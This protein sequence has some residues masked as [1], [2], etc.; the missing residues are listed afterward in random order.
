MAG[1]LL[2]AAALALV[3]GWGAAV[4]SLRA[5]PADDQFAVAANHFR[6]ANWKLA[7][8]EFRALVERFPDDARAPVA[9][10]YLGEAQ[11]QLGDLAGAQK[12]FDGY[13]RK[14]PDGEHARTALFRSGESAHVAGQAAEADRLLRAFLQKNPKDPL[15][16]YV[17][18]YLGEIASGKGDFE[19][20]AAWFGQ[21]LKD[22]PNGPLQDDCRYGLGRAFRELGRTEEA[23]RLF[24]A[25]SAKTGSPRADEALFYLGVMQ[26]DATRPEE[27]VKSFRELESKFS[28]SPQLPA[29]RLLLG[30]ALFQLQRWDEARTALEGLK[31]DARLGVRARYW[32]GRVQQEQGQWAAAAS[33]LIAAAEAAP[34]H[35]LE[36]EIRFEAGRSLAKAG[37]GP[38]AQ[39]QFD[40]AIAAS[41]ENGPWLDEALS[42]KAQAALALKDHELVDRTAGQFAER[43]PRS[44]LAAGVART[45]AQSLIERGRYPEALEK[46]EPWLANAGKD[47]EGLAARY[48]A[49]LAYDGVGRPKDALDQL[50]RAGASDDPAVR[51]GALLAKAGIRM[52]AEQFSEAAA[53]LQALL[54]AA[55]DEQEALAARMRLAV[56]LARTRQLDEAR[57]MYA[58]VVEQ[59]AASEAFPAFEE[60]LA[61]AALDAGDT[62]WSSAL[63]ERLAAGGGQS[64]AEK[65]GLA[66]LGWSQL[67]AGRLSDAAAT[68]GRL[69]QSDPPAALAAEAAHVR[70]TILEKL[71]QPDAALAMY[72]RVIDKHPESQQRADALLAAAR[73]RDRLDQD[74][75]AVALF[76]RFVRD[77]PEHAE[78]DRALY[79]WAWAL[80]DLKR[81]EAATAAFQRIHLEF[82]QSKVWPDATYRLAQQAFEARHLAEAKKLTSAVLDAACSADLRQHVLYL[83]GQIAAAESDWDE[84]R[85][86]FETLAKDHPEG[87]FRWIAEFWTAESSYRKQDYAAAAAKL[88]EIAQQT[89][90]RGDPWLA[91]IPLRRAQILAH[92]EKWKE[93]RDLAAGI[94]KDSPQ[95]D[96]MYQVDYV[97]GRCLAMEARFDEARAAYQRVIHSPQGAKTETAAKAQWMIGETYHHQKDYEAALRAY[98][99]VEFLYDFPEWQAAALLQAAKCR[100]ALGEWNEAVRLYERLMKEYPD[101][102]YNED[103]GRRLLEARRRVTSGPAS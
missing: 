67:R 90:G 33:T 42:E 66:G 14:Y 80:Q 52:R 53:V 98:H 68:F 97:L 21:G 10:F 6:Q 9:L 8:E 78:L 2:K 71:R 64:E 46:L 73:L 65:R 83:K 27:A 39:K 7:A 55:P 57:A 63:F 48:L 54:A 88:Q 30:K 79:D 32:L 3:L 37:D 69:L 103:A 23:T 60:Q 92:Q 84:V 12:S 61:E 81:G 29:A 76:E 16:A 24:L 44:P 17:L 59:H 25:V 36:A 15:N 94:A 5:G 74:E 51:K 45:W 86:T 93:A 34:E 22:F 82:R 28:K 19:D 41:G 70:G 40:L 75:Q 20:A 99:R 4:S 89:R 26:L 77:F 72:D 18:T 47:E 35:A 85:D 43:C 101:T 11:L 13:L 62:Q 95:F 102:P 100:E 49:G 96:Q 58:E 31:S 56:C 1:K 91:M 38:A 87:P 50:D